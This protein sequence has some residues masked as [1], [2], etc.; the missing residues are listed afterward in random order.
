ML[1]RGRGRATPISGDATLRQHAKF[2]YHPTVT[3]TKKHTVQKNENQRYINHDSHIDPKHPAQFV[4][5]FLPIEVK[6]KNLALAAAGHEQFR[7]AMI[8]Y[9]EHRVVQQVHP[10]SSRA[11]AEHIAHDTRPMVSLAVPMSMVY[12]PRSMAMIP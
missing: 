11:R 6:P 12:S 8:V 7:A 9:P 10:N 3:N 2:I 1:C 4:A 5:R